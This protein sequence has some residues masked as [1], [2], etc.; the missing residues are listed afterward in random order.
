MPRVREDCVAKLGTCAPEIWAPD[1]EH[2]KAMGEVVML[3][4]MLILQNCS[5][6]S[7]AVVMRRSCCCRTPVKILAQEGDLSRGGCR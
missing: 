5:D 7:Q 4:V 2:C 6:G 3:L 1:V